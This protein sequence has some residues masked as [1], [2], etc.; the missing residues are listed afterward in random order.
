MRCT[1]LIPLQPT[2]K[3]G[4]RPWHKGGTASMPLQQVSR[5]VVRCHP[6]TTVSH[7]H[8]RRLHH[9][10]LSA[11]VSTAW[12][13]VG[14]DNTH[15]R[16]LWYRALHTFG[17]LGQLFPLFLG[18]RVLGYET[19]LL[20]PV[21]WFTRVVAPRKSPFLSLPPLSLFSCSLLVAI[22]LSLIS[23]RTTVEV[24]E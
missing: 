12:G 21:F 5:C 8:L 10:V 23:Q 15:T 1:E 24:Q 22:A 9:S 20:G 4:A 3:Q 18:R 7:S 19:R 13:Y 6:P 17:R 11:A 14:P 16:V 2:L